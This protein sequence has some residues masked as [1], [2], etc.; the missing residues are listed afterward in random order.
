MGEVEYNGIMNFYAIIKRSVYD[1]VRYG[2]AGEDVGA[3]YKTRIQCCGTL[4]RLPWNRPLV[5]Q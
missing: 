5:L 3:V 4:R 1:N 2:A